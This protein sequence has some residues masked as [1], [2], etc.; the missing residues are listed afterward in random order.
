MCLRFAMT[1]TNFE[2]QIHGKAEKPAKVTNSEDCGRHISPNYFGK[3]KLPN[4]DPNDKHMLHVH[5]IIDAC[6]MQWVLLT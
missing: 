3:Q 5:S 4:H 6:S 2:G 1:F